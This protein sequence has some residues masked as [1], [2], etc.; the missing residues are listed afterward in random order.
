MSKLHFKPINLVN[1]QSGIDEEDES[2]NPAT[3][4]KIYDLTIK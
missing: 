2:T 1:L 3:K 4:A